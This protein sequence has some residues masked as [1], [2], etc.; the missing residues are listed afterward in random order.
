MSH[1][2]LL[3]TRE[4]SKRFGKRLVV[5]DLNLEV[6]KGDIFGFLGPNGAGKS[7]TIKMLFGLVRPTSGKIEIFGHPLSASRKRALKRVCGIV[8]QPDFYLQLSARKNLEILGVLSGGIRKER[9]A[10][11][12][13]LVRLN[14]QANDK[15]KTFSHGMKQ[16]LGIAQALL[17]E[18]ELIILDEPTTGLDPQGMKEVRELIARLSEEEGITILLSSHLLHEIEQT[19]T[20][21]AIIHQGQLIV[22]GEVHA[23]LK[24]LKEDVVIVKAAPLDD[25]A[26]LLKGQDW[27]SSLSMEN[28][29]MEVRLASGSV[30]DMNAFL[31]Q[32]NIRVSAII[33]K[34]SLEDYFLSITENA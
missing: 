30:A 7:T 10:Q 33:P 6:H 2:L 16:R 22:Q 13:D 24:D 14:G 23:L 34:R 20:R 26:R 15:V 11:V 31:V 21:M 1:A 3:A 27:V 29:G 4:L 5:D 12:L 18:P 32:N 8:E 9:I 28:D 17:S 19:A 25:A